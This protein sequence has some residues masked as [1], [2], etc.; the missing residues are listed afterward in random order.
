MRIGLADAQI[1]HIQLFIRSGDPDLSMLRSF[2]TNW[3]AYTNGGPFL[4][5][6]GRPRWL[7]KFHPVKH[8]ILLEACH[9]CSLEAAKLIGVTGDKGDLVVDHAIPFSELRK[10]LDAAP[11]TSAGIAQCLKENLCLGVITTA[12]NKKLDSLNLR[13]S[14]PTGRSGARARYEFAGIK[15]REGGKWKK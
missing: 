3:F 1:A 12:E 4:N 13:S 5:R 15:M 14:M 9:L 6:N 8:A 10:L 7:N 11:K 2:V